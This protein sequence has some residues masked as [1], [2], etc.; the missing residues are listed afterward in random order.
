[1]LNKDEQLRK[2]FIR[3]LNQL[4]ESKVGRAVRGTENW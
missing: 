4:G 3:S 2:N 1:M